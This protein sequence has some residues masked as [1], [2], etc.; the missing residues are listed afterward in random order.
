MIENY[1]TKQDKCY[2]IAEIGVNHNGEMNLAKELI[3]AAKESGADAAKFQTF[4]ASSLVSKG[5]PK[6]RYQEDT[7]SKEESHYEMIQKLEFKFE[8]HGEIKNYCDSKGIDFLS[9]AYDVESAIF[10][11]KLGVKAFKTASADIVDMPLQ[12]YI[13][14]TGKPSIVSVGMATMQEIQDLVELYEESKNQDIILLHCVSN[15]PCSDQSLNLRVIQALKDEFKVPVGYSDHS[16]GSEAAMISMAYDVKVIEKHFTL[17][18]TMNG[19]DHKASSTPEEFKALVDNIRRAEIALGSPVKSCQEEEKQMS[20]VS[21]KSIMAKDKIRKGETISAEKIT[22]KRPGTG[23]NGFQ[24]A[25]V[26]GKKAKKEIEIDEM[27]K[28][29]EI[30]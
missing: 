9:T 17:D 13:A 30:E 18:K 24:L 2:M 14:E 23:L 21:R 3:D 4:K 28:L 10:L 26:I 7:T 5:T 11:D 19:P 25:D 29:E 12:K 22:L 20:T 8:D 27:I 6:V 1:F 16:I 15:Y